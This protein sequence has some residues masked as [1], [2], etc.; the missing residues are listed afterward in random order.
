MVVQIGTVKR[1]AA[2]LLH[3]WLW[4]VWG[5]GGKPVWAVNR[6]GVTGR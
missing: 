2:I 5:F 4:A 3:G 6:G 1:S